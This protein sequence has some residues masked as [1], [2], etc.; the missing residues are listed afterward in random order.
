MRRGGT[1]KSLGIVAAILVTGLVIVGGVVGWTTLRERPLADPGALALT[2]VVDGVEAEVAPYRVCDL[3]DPGSCTVHEDRVHHMALG[4]Q[5]TAE[6][7]VDPEVASVKWTL[8]RFYADESAN[9]TALHEPGTATAETVAGS[10]A[11][12]GQRSALG[13]IEVS[14]AVVGLDAAGEETTYGITWSIVNDA[15]DAVDAATE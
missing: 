10:T 1:R 6:V 8:Q 2:V 4:A 5:D 13:V 7:R 12:A 9:A 15:A 14:T 3:F 11:A